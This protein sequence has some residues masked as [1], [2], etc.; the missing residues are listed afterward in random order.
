MWRLWE[1]AYKVN[2]RT[3]HTR[4]NYGL[5]LHWVARHVEAVEILESVVA[6][7]P[8]DH[9]ARFAFGVSAFNVR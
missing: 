4:Y 9:S 6:E 5:E 3:L 8:E 7:R 2:P 1:S